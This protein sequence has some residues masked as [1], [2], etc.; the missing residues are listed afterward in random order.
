MAEYL[1]RLPRVSSRYA[2]RRGYAF[3]MALAALPFAL[4]IGAWA[5]FVL[6][7]FGDSWCRAGVFSWMLFSIII[8]AWLSGALLW[9]TGHRSRRRMKWSGLAVMTLA[10]FMSSVLF[11]ILTIFTDDMWDFRTNGLFLLPIAGVSGLFFSNFLTLGLHWPAGILT[12]L[13]FR[14]SQS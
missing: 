2:N 12:S 7:N 13:L 9:P 10:V 8:S 5:A 11:S 6:S 4:I 1:E 14:E 3:A